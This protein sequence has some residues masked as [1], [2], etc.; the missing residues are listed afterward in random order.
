[1]PS[2]LVG[3]PVETLLEILYTENEQINCDHRDFV[4]DALSVATLPIVLVT[5]TKV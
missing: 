4:Y 1:M 3:V 5:N 2:A